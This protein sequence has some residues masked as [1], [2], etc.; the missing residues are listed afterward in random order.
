MREH[1]GALL[2]VASGL[3]ELGAVAVADGDDVVGP[4][5]QVDLPGLDGVLLVDVPERLEHHEHVVAVALQL[6]TLVGGAGILDREGVQVE[7]GGE[8]GELRR[9]G[10]EHSDPLEVA[11]L[12]LEPAGAGAGPVTGD[13][14]P[15]AVAIEGVVHDHPVRL[16]PLGSAPWQP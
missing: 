4:E 9:L 12:L 5:E 10:V 3:R 7:L 16:V 13:I 2:E 15:L 8:L 11:G 6:G 14:D 1:L